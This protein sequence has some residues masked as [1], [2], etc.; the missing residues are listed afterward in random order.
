MCSIDA[1]QLSQ[2]TMNEYT[3]VAHLVARTNF[4]W[5]VAVREHNLQQPIGCNPTTRRLYL[6][7]D[8]GAF[9]GCRTDHPA[10][11]MMDAPEY[12]AAPLPIIDSA[13]LFQTREFLIIEPILAMINR[14]MQDRA[15]WGRLLTDLAT[16]GLQKDD[17]T[18]DE[19][20]EA[21]K[22]HFGTVGPIVDASTRT[23]RGG[24]IYLEFDPLPEGVLG[25]L[26]KLQT[27]NILGTE[28][29]QDGS[30]MPSGKRQHYR[31]VS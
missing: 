30:M 15:K 12:N 11:L 6:P 5:T 31:Y 25:H 18:W 1:S 2:P 26:I 8:G 24:S 20:R 29:D 23:L 4:E 17:A 10:R 13:T 27:M 7:L 16:L 19:V 3:Q 14:D 21:Y 22:G 28:T 9:I